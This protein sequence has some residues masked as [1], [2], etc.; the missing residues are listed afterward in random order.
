VVMQLEVRAGSTRRCPLAGP[1]FPQPDS[2]APRRSPPCGRRLTT[3]RP[4]LVAAMPGVRQAL[5]SVDP[6]MPIVSMVP[7]TDVIAQNA[8]MWVV[9]LAAVLFGV[10]G[11]LALLL[12]VVGVYGVKSYAVARRT[13]EIGIRMALGSRPA[14]VFALLM[15]QALLQTA[16]A[17][18][19]GLLLALATGRVLARI[20]YQV[21]AADPLALAVATAM[22][23]AASL[24]ACFLPARRATRVDPMS[25]LRSD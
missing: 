18:A 11:A 13:R 15:K 1:A 7:F 17:L 24:V 3:D 10:F 25:A 22:L 9:R 21:S 23:A 19:V 12:A 4:A 2:T 6:D 8:G 14:D 16:L 5:R 20:V